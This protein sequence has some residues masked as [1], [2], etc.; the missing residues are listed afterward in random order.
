MSD[1]VPRRR[2]DVPFD[3]G[4]EVEEEV[5]GAGEDAG[6]G[7]VPSRSFSV[8]EKGRTEVKSRV[9]KLYRSLSEIVRERGH[10]CHQTEGEG[11]DQ[12]C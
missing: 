11:E 3:E 10:L 4:R 5:G 9:I 2:D 8:E 1:Y 7:A 12:T 6:A